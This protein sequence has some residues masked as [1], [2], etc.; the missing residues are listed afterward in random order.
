ML[1]NPANEI[2]A[3]ADVEDS[4]RLAGKDVDEEHHAAAQWVPAFAGTPKRGLSEQRRYLQFGGH[5]VER[6]AQF[7]RD[8]DAV[9]SPLL[10]AAVA[11]LARQA[12]LVET[13]QQGRAVQLP[14][15]RVDL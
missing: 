15:H 6:G 1:P 10:D 2:R 8:R 12:D 5:L 14:D 13:R 9:L 7:A 4:V 11:V 3:A